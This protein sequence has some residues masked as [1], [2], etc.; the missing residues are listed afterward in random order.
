MVAMGPTVAVDVATCLRWM[1][2]LP[3]RQCTYV[4]LPGRSVF[5]CRP[6]HRVEAMRPVDTLIVVLYR[7]DSWLHMQRIQ[8]AAY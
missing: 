6:A 2:L 1:A 8:L 7:V 5:R 3:S 4:V